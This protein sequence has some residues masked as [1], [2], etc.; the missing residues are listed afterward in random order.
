L[1][2]IKFQTRNFVLL[3]M[4]RDQPLF[5]LII[6]PPNDESIIV[7]TLRFILNLVPLFRELLGGGTYMNL[8]RHA[9]SP[10]H[11]I[12]FIDVDT[13]FA[14]DGENNIRHVFLQIINFIQN[15]DGITVYL[16]SCERRVTGI[17]GVRIYRCANDED[18]ANFKIRV[19]RR[20]N[21]LDNDYNV[22]SFGGL[23]INQ[24]SILD[25]V[26]INLENLFQGQFD[27]N[28]NSNSI[29]ELLLFFIIVKRMI[30]NNNMA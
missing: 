29:L 25:F 6:N 9:T 28:E 15:Q 18:K 13:T 2:A 24:F 4:N 5:N 23:F 3:K 12:L 7:S 1:F 11:L 30:E 19:L 22:I 26:L 27:P 14:L 21:R 8:I 17:R 16:L 10:S 20:E